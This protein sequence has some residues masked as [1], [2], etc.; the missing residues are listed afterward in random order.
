MPAS[1]KKFPD[2]PTDWKWWDS[3]VP[4]RLRALYNKEE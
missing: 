1:G 4:D 2:S 3:S